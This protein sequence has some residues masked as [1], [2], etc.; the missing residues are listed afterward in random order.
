MGQSLYGSVCPSLRVTQ[1]KDD[2]RCAAASKVA[3]EIFGEDGWKGWGFSAHTRGHW[4]KA[5][6]QSSSYLPFGIFD[7]FPSTL[8]IVSFTLLCM[9]AETKEG[10]DVDE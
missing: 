6:P 9:V 1:G 7:P 8:F 2:L 5:F 10:G 3:C 4:G